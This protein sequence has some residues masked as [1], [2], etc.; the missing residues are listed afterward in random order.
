LPGK[1]RISVLVAAT[2][3]CAQ[4]A[5]AQARIADLRARFVREPS[6]V[7]KAKLMPQLGD[8]EFAEVD[9]DV[10]QGKLQEALAVLNQYRD[11][12]DACVPKSILR[13]SSSCNF[14]CG[15]RCVAWTWSS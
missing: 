13:D 14:P 3:L 6:P 11:E 15:T 5:V 9:T 10:A 2:V 12:I 1:I 4:A 8:A 7:N